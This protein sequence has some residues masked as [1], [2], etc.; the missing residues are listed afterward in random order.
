MEAGWRVS[1]GVPD[2]KE[3]PD[4]A[5]VPQSDESAPQEGREAKLQ[6]IMRGETLAW[7]ERTATDDAERTI[8]KAVEYGSGDLDIMA[9]AM[10]VTHNLPITKPGIVL[11][12]E[13]ACAF[14]LLGKVGRMMEAYAK[15]ESPS[16]DCWFDATVYAMMARRI[17]RT[18]QWP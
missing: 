8:P 12:K 11:G 10:L 13:M 14:Y 1:R 7:W 18:E 16:A 2:V 5:S 17:R 4:D 9:M 6:A 15:G 3:E